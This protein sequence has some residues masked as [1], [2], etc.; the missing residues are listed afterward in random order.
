MSDSVTRADSRTGESALSYGLSGRLVFTNKGWLVLTVPN[1][2]GRGAFDALH[3]VGAEFP[4]EP[5]SAHIS[6][7]SPEDISKIGGAEK[8][9]ERGHTFSYTLGSIRV[10]SPSGWNVSKL[11]YIEIR[12]PELEQLRRSYG[13]SSTPGGN[14]FPFHVA[15]AVRR[16]GVLRENDIAKK[17]SFVHDFEQWRRMYQGDWPRR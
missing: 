4:D 3:E 11:W 14:D 16:R 12:S 7:F 13:L 8:I 2:L 15:F 6:V 17:A 1:A 10:A 5:Y 9:S